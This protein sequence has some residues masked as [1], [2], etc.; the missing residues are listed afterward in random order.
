MSKKQESLDS[1]LVALKEALVE[2]DNVSLFGSNYDLLEKAEILMCKY[3]S[4]VGYRVYKNPNKTNIKHIDQLLDFFYSTLNYHHGEDLALVSNRDKDKALV[5]R[6]VKK[7]QEALNCS[8]EQAIAD[9]VLIIEAM[10]EKEAELALDTAL[11]TWVFG[12]GKCSWVT[13]K[14]INI[15]NDERQD[16]NETM[17]A[18]KVL[19][20]EDELGENFFTGFNLK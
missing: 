7:R 18:Q 19:A 1:T 2:L 16:A 3:L 14:I 6:F 10:F 20:F 12:T 9:T 8:N 15:I 13:D 4:S 5:G 11:G 17:I